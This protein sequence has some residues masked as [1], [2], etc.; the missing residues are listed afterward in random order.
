MNQ[1][2]RRPANCMSAKATGGWTQRQAGDGFVDRDDG[3]GHRCLHLRRRSKQPPALAAVKPPEGPPAR[4]PDE[5]ARPRPQRVG[6]PGPQS[7]GYRVERLLCR[8]QS[9][10]SN[11][12]TPSWSFLAGY[13]QVAARAAGGC[14]RADRIPSLPSRRTSR[15]ASA[16][17]AGSNCGWPSLPGSNGPTTASA[18]SAGLAA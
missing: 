1:P 6:A 13:A 12:I 14:A 3:P 2:P 5:H 17:P 7:G 8:P 15:T 9:V 18:A 10:A 4:E 11:A 16:G